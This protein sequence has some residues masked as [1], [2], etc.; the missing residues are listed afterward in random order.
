MGQD[1]GQVGAPVES[2]QKSP[3]EIRRDIEDTR[4]DLGDTAEALAAKTDVKTRA[5]ERVEGLKQTIAEKRESIGSSQGG[6]AAGGGTAKANAVVE[7]AK[8]KANEN[9]ITTAA[10]A[11]FVGGFVIGRI[12]SRS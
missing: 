4:Q 11:A 5:K 2:E 12:T 3:E 8:A 10:L 1:E 7:Q 6:D 9:P